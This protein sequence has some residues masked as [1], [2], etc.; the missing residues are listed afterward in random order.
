[1]PSYSVSKH[2]TRSPNILR[3]LCLSPILTASL[4]PNV[5]SNW[6]PSSVPGL[7]RWREKA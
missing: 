2:A 1:M 4:S 5:S 7:Q 6:R 3:Q